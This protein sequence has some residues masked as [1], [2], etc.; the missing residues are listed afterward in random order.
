MRRCHTSRARRERRDRCDDRAAAAAAPAATAARYFPERFGFQ[1][2]GDPFEGKREHAEQARQ[3]APE[4]P[5]AADIPDGTYRGSCT[6]CALADGGRTLTCT[7]CVNERRARVVTSIAVGACAA[8]ETIG[9][10][11]GALTCELAP[12]APPPRPPADPRAD[13][14]G[15]PVDPRAERFVKMLRHGVPRP[16]V[17]KKMEAEGLDPALLD[18]VDVGAARSKP[19]FHAGEL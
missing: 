4:E 8:D 5:N 12:V 17:E 11:N 18:G 2:F 1:P 16:A 15:A 7:Q 14:G 3:R 13:D 6:G 9:N 10:R 19:P